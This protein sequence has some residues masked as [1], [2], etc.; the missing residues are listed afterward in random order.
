MIETL[1]DRYIPFILA[2][3]LLFCC[4]Q[5]NGIVMDAILY[6]TQYVN[7]IDPSRF[8]FDPAFE[9]GNQDSLGLF[10]PISKIF[11]GMFGVDKGAFTFTFLMHLLWGVAIF[12]L[13]KNILKITENRLWLFP[14]VCL[15]IIVFANGMPFSRILFFKYVECYFCSRALSIVLGVIGLALVLS[16]KKL[17][18]LFL[19]VLGTAVHPITAGWCLPFWMMYFYPKLRLSIIVFSILLPFSFLLHK[20]PFD[21][22]SDDWLSRPLEFSPSYVTVGRYFALLVFWWITV[23]YFT[24]NI[25]VKK[26]ALSLIVLLTVALYWNC[27]GGF[28]E[29]VFLYQVQ[30]WRFLWIPSILAMPIYF[31]FLKDAVKRF[32]KKKVLT[33]HDCALVLIGVNMLAPQNLFAVSVFCMVLLIMKPKILSCKNVVAVFVAIW[34]AFL[35]VQQYQIMVI[36]GLNPIFDY[37]FSLLN[38]LKISLLF[39]QLP[40]V[41]YFAAYF[42]CNRKFIAALFCIVYCFAS[43]FV[44]LPF[45]AFYLGFVCF[46]NKKKFWLCFVLLAIVTFIEGAVGVELRCSN[47]FDG[48]PRKIMYIVFFIFVMCIGASLLKKYRRLFVVVFFLAC[49]GYAYSHYD[50]RLE[51][52]K[53]NEGSLNGYVEQTIFPEVRDR[54]HILFFVDG[55]YE[56]EPRIR[57]LTG[58]YYS[59]SIHIG[60]LF[61]KKHYQEA[62]RR[63]RLLCWKNEEKK[64]PDFSCHIGVFGKLQNIDTLIDRTHFLC[65]KN[66]ISHLVTHYEDFPFVKEDS[67]IT[68]DGK[69]VYLY[70]CN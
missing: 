44:L 66:E 4:H 28:G 65:S 26:I 1:K 46:K 10:F 67:S 25:E 62:V 11:F 40:F 58:S 57:F 64:G 7:L 55:F 52:Q 49:C 70:G 34:L 53:K 61:Y 51:I 69:K 39:C 12:F 47:F 42:T 19:I 41:V 8:V 6:V 45:V 2:I 37:D 50:A 48:F 5:Y 3:P 30:T 16:N 15:V 13:V 43:R 60:G 21:F 24:K 9:F 31:V 38:N 18:S 22:F 35:L 32:R 14:A 20:G 33:T 27:W 23:K 36:Q 29:H 59:S 68:F 56:N 54:G 17:L 63:S